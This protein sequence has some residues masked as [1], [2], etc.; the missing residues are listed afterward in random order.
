MSW[1]CEDSSGMDTLH[2]LQATLVYGILC[3]TC[4]D[5][6]A[7]SDADLVVGTIEV[8]S[9]DTILCDTSDQTIPW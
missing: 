4:T 2:A 9:P 7:R 1:Q 5:S 8:Y 3:S 6:V